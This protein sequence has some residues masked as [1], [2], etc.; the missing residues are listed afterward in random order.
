L[1]DEPTN[2]LDI[3]AVRWLER[4]LAG[5]KGGAAIISH[6]RYLLDRVVDGVVEVD[7]TKLSF[8]PGNYS[9]YV[10][11]RE[12]RALTQDRQYEKDKAFIDK[13]RAFIAKHL[14]GQRTAEA[15]GRRTRLNREIKAGEYLQDRSSR[16]KT[17]AFEFDL[18]LPR[19]RTMIET[20]RL[21]KSFDDKALFS[22]LSLQI[23]SGQ[24]LGI[25]GPN[26][27]GKSSLLK[28]ILGEFN[29]SEGEVHIDPKAEI[30]YYAQEAHD[31]DQDATVLESIHEVRPD[32]LEVRVRSLLGA[33]LFS[34]DAVFKR[35]G[36]LS[37]GEQSRIRLIR[38]LLKNPN[39]LVLDEPTNHLDIPSREALETALESY[40]GTIVAVSHDRYFLDRIV[41]HLLVMRSGSH[42]S[43]FGNYSDYVRQLEAEAPDTGKTTRKRT[44]QSPKKDGP[45]ANREKSRFEKM[46]L[47]E[48][49][50]TI[51]E[52]EEQLAGCHAQFADENVYKDAGALAS[53]RDES[54]RLQRELEQAEAVWTLRAEAG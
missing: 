3:D 12:L 43:T 36:S 17:I 45:G 37:G 35:V 23:A 8:F 26:G 5:H 44:K 6:D 4:F 15:K 32:L 33:F 39:V 25:T 47:H 34:G 27:T 2:H 41:T 24:R 54:G 48:L 53:V 1:L 30:G 9:N 16:H 10:K 18:E 42:R 52:F 11:T 28:V 7:R 19:D 31:L 40:P 22:E 50:A 20:D 14:A 46:S 49:E 38:L 51:I 13:E 29:A 21:A